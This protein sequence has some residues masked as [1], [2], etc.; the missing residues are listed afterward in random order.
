MKLNQS[1]SGILPTNLPLEVYILSAVGFFVALG[2]GL[3]I[4]A[5]PLFAGHFHANNTQVGSIVAS[6]GAARFFAGLI[7]G[8]LLDR[9]GIRTILTLGLLDVA[10]SMVLAG[11]SQSFWEL[12]AFRTFGGL[13]SSMFSVSVSAEIMRVV[14]SD[15]LGRAQSLYNGTFIIGTMSG[16]LFG[17][18]L[19]AI[20][21][22]APFFIYAL[23]AIAAAAV[24]YIQLSGKAELH[25]EEKV[26]RKKFSLKVALRSYPYL[27]ALTFTFLT[28][29]VV[30]GPRN[31][32]V[33]L[34]VTKYLHASDFT[35]GFSLAF[36]VLAQAIF[37]I[38]AGKLS[39]L[40]GRRFTILVGSG[41]LLLASFIASDFPRI[42]FFFLAMAFYGAGAAFL[43]TAS[44]NIVGDLFHG[45]G[46]KVIGFWQMSG[47]LAMIIAPLLVGLISDS[48]SYQAAF[49]ISGLIFL[50]APIMAYRLPKKITSV[51]F[52]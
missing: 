39:D 10:L 13:G 21:L 2:Y 33:P 31:S 8:K 27:A 14:K 41:N 15:H 28:N 24:S 26:D 16:P 37:L 1:R 6:F 45:I 25:P 49:G 46:G 50:I 48:L 7:S 23:T 32:I 52:N 36:T 42:A 9:F 47:D 44:S 11:F 19:V 51:D 29:F 34:Y 4:P 40:R 3:I 22:R 12:L 30:F 17:G 20:S 43:T 5:L 18:I 38:P 35:L